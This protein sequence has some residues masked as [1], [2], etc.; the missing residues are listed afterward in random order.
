MA[1]M[2]ITND[3]FHDEVLNSDKTVL[4]DFYADWC[5][6]CQMLSPILE[7]ISAERS[8]VKIC[9]VNVDDEPQLTATFGINSIPALFVIKNSEVTAQSLGLRS[10]EDILKML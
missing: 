2:M 10:K 9:K 8:D 1:F 5:G 4:L 3:N 6:P 7:E